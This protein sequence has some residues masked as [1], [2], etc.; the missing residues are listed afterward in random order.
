[1]SLAGS[2]VALIGATGAVGE[3]ILRVLEARRTRPEELR[4]L[5]SGESRGAGV[6]FA[7]ET[8]WVEELS[9]EALGD[10]DAAVCAAP[11]ILETLLP[12]L[13]ERGIALVDLSGVLELEAEVP[14]ALPGRLCPGPWVAVPRGI[15]SGLLV[16]LLPIVELEAL[17]RV[18]ATTLESA[19]GAGRR[20]LEELQGQTVRV[21]SA[22]SGEVEE[23]RVFPR[24]LAFDCLP[25]VGD[26]DAQGETFEE[27]RLRHVLRRAFGLPALPV[28]VTRVRV[29]TFMG[30]LASVQAELAK[31]LGRSA[32]EQAWRQAPALRL[33][34]DSELPS[35][36]GAAAHED[37]E[38]GR[39]RC[40]EER[41]VVSFVIALDT[42]RRGA[43]LGAVE[44]L[45]GVL[46]S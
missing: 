25:A 39:V 9:E 4:L 17:E 6:E 8:L 23:T 34:S 40:E 31:P 11:L 28:E 37:V 29:P 36:R 18:T 21:L 35:P 33:L 19:S 14:L 42:L 41:A 22:M 1:M 10:C 12:A 30:A 3:E 26:L 5:A 46:S 16:A 38:I 15:V 20:G 2:R 45:E 7:G 24:M 27:R 32:L 43:A 13:R 44:A